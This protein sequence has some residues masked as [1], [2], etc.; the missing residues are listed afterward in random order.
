MDR[1]R[2]RK[3]A[4]QQKEELDRVAALAKFDKLIADAH[5]E[6]A[7]MEVRRFEFEDSILQWEAE[8]AKLQGQPS[9]SKE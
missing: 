6:L 7:L 9:L 3:E 8:K 4:E 1:P 5:R 2:S